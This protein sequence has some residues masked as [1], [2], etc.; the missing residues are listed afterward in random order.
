MI[1][2]RKAHPQGLTYPFLGT[3]MRH[4]RRARRV[5]YALVLASLAV[6][7]VCTGAVP[8]VAEPLPTNPELI[9]GAL[10]NGLT[11]IIKKHGNPAGGV[12]LW[13]HVASGSLNETDGARGIAHYL[14]HMA[15]NGS[16]NFLPGSLV[17]FFQS[18]GMTFG[19][20]Q[21]AFTGFE[22]T[23][24]Q[25]ALPD[26]KPETLDKGM[27]FLSDVAMRL[28]LAPVEIENERQIILEEKRWRAGPA[29][30]VQE[31][32]YGR[33]APGSTL[34]RRLPIGAEET[35]RSAALKDFKEYYS[36]WYV[37]SNMAIIVVGDCDPALVVGVIQK[38]F[39]AG[40]KVPR[41]A[42]HDVG[43]KPQTG[44]RAIVA[45]DPELTQAEVSFVRVEPPH[46]PTI[47]VEQR[48][49]D[50]VELIGI[51]VFNRRISAQLAE[52]KASFLKAGVSVRQEGRAIRLVTAE[53]SGK[54]SEWRR[55]LAD[56]GTNL[57]RA[58]LHGFSEREV[59]DVR[60]SLIAKAEDA[61]EREGTL[62]ARTI[63][64]QI[65][66]ALARREP[67]MSA[68]QRLELLK[69]LLP[70]ITAA[71]VSRVFAAS[72]DPTNVT[73]I[74]E[75]P[76]G[77]DVPSEAELIGLGRAALSVKPDREAEVARA[78]SLLEKLPT[79]GKLV[80]STEHATSGV[81][82]GWLDNGARVHY[83]FVDQR[84]NEASITVTLAGGR[85]QETGANR[86]ITDAAALAWSRPATSKLSS[87]RIRD[88][89][90]G[91]KVRVSGGVDQDILTLTV[92]GNPADLEAGLQ[93]AY[94]LLTDPIIEP[95]AFEQW[96]ETVRQRIASRK[97]Q[98]AGVLSETVAAAFY[99]NDEPR[100]RP[101]AADQIQRVRVD[102]AQAWLKKIIATAPIEVAV[103]GDLDRTTAR[104]LVERYLGSLPARDRVSDRTFASLR[105]ITRT[106]GPINVSRKINVKTLQA[107][108]M[109]GFFGADIQNVRDSRLLAMAGRVLSTR[110]NTVLRE[111][112]QLVYRIGASSQPAS[113]YPG[114][115]LFVARAPT[116]PAK[117]EALATAV[118]EMYAAFAKDGPT[119]NEMAV[120][121]K[122]LANLL[123]Q[124]MKEPDFWV[125]Q[126]STLDYRGLS[127]ND[128]VHA[129]A[130]Y[131]RY[132]AAEIR[133]AFARYNTPGA[134][135]RFLIT[136]GGPTT[137]KTGA[138]QT[139]G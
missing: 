57:Q 70:G 113:E 36:R 66:G 116:D 123:D 16:A 122:Q 24:Y 25:L 138:E 15:F 136:P 1:N 100:T 55:I 76:S 96:K 4:M 117:A 46:A 127:L 35:I 101:L 28:S 137:G 69:R 31:Y 56:L 99:P 102:A 124:T 20:D 41:P 139:K 95:A 8:A 87:I 45:T 68:S 103:V 97:L 125:S 63:L 32:I 135:F 2:D 75:L 119:E 21:N 22:Q 72:F 65:N 3:T 33:L 132:T 59:Q 64:R 93:L 114:F 14:E 13:L 134:R 17:P 39:A 67:V 130:D 12:G 40:P 51:R 9:R 11:Y 6:C 128:L 118:N 53:G 42:D 37:P 120:V 10:D 109:D 44:A 81:T 82:S 105:K 126:L 29:Q 112:K 86:G 79:G 121:K 78:S 90:T 18:L 110:M 83:R 89:M 62:P 26:T 38:H 107:I 84:K 43:V 104:R 108:V 73:F 60:R 54:P 131:Q 94:L 92:S 58:R 74:A 71:E 30:R 91:K 77:G 49:D 52:G 27:L 23:T 80:E 48:R 85:I 50:L 98:P 34:G 47:T 115:G 5:R 7:L 129:P 88:W 111:E 133:D 106:V 19:R 61:V